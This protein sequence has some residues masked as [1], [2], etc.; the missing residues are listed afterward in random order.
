M[1]QDSEQRFLREI[2]NQ[3]AFADAAY[4]EMRRAVLQVRWGTT[5]FNAQNFLV[6]AACVAKLLWPHPAAKK[7]SAFRNQCIQR[8]DDLRQLLGIL[9]TSP[10]RDRWLR[11]RFEHFDEDLQAWQMQQAGLA[12]PNPVPL[13][14]FPDLFG[15]ATISRGSG[16]REQSMVAYVDSWRTYIDGGKPGDPRL[17][18]LGRTVE[19]APIHD[20]LLDI[21]RKAEDKIVLSK[22]E[23]P[24][25]RWGNRGF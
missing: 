21:A 9:D 14:Q 6:A 16:E 1:D 22:M 7:G 25:G 23:L 24:H 11:D 8:G 13:P 5:F 19:L 4:D 15:G 10:V 17:N 2:A 18:L 3:C 12:A 20:G